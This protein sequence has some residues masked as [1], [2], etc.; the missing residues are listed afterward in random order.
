VVLRRSRVDEF[1]HAKG[2]IMSESPLVQAP[3]GR[4]VG[5]TIIAILTIIAG[6]IAI[7][8]GILGFVGLG[9]IGEH[10][11]RVFT[12]IVTIGLVIA[13]LSGIAA[14]IVGWG[15][16]T[17]KSWAFW[18]L[19]VVEVITILDH[20]FDWFVAHHISIGSLIIDVALPVIILV[21]LFVDRN[22]RAAFRT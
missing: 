14:L 17:L 6:L 21:Y 5:V 3:Q 18:T 15:L 8:G 2:G 13:I 7:I 11:P 10:F 20:L 12:A 19:V 1:S 22:V 4:P 16:W 9:I